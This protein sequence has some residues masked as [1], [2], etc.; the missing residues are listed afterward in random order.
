MKKKKKQKKKTGGAERVA[1]ERLILKMIFQ[2]YKTCVKL[3]KKEK[4]SCSC[5]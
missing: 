4:A 2:F 3:V 1:E 5:K